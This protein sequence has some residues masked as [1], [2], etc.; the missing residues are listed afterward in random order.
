MLGAMDGNKNKR[1]ASDRAKKAAKRAAS[2]EAR[3]RKSQKLLQELGR[4]G[5]LLAA[6]Q[7]WAEDPNHGP[8]LGAPAGES[9]EPSCMERSP[10][11]ARLSRA[12]DAITV[13]SAQ[14][15]SGMEVDA[16]D[17]GEL[18]HVAAAPEAVMVEA[19]ADPRQQAGPFA[20]GE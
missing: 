10:I 8:W 3:D 17:A 20:D 13:H 1:Q 19:A 2:Q 9:G 14:W 4:G 16:H 18:P 15:L 5:P 7:E 11:Q 12:T 6:L